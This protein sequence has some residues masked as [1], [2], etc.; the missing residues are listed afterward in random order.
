MSTLTS[1]SVRSP[2]KLFGVTVDDELT[3][4]QQQQQLENVQKRACRDILGHANANY[5]QKNLQK[6]TDDSWKR[7][8]QACDSSCE[9]H[10][11]DLVVV[12]SNHAMSILSLPRLSI[13]HREALEKLGRSL[14]LH[15]RLRHLLPP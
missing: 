14:L 6:L 15:P 5:S 3:S 2:A 13:K 12:W 7:L 11:Q 8:V 1:Y 4:T 9:L 10:F